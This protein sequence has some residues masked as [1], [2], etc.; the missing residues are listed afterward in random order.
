MRAP[1]IISIVISVLIFGI[2]GLVMHEVMGPNLCA[3]QIRVGV[4]TA[5]AA[6]FLISTLAFVKSHKSN[7]LSPRRVCSYALVVILSVGIWY[8]IWSLQACNEG[9]RSDMVH[10]SQ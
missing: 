8:E 5:L 4:A 1:R 6:I 10:Q 7:T 9:P 2:V 3:H